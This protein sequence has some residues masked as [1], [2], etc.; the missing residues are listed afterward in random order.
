MPTPKPKKTPKKKKAAPKKKAPAKKNTP[1]KAAP[2]KAAQKK[3]AP[4]K[5]V[6]G[7]LLLVDRP[8]ANQQVT[9]VHYDVK[10]FGGPGEID[11]SGENID[12]TLT[13]DD[14]F[15]VSQTIGS[16]VTFVGGFTGGGG[17]HIDVTVTENGS[18]IGSGSFSGNTFNKAIK[19]TVK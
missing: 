18:Q 2:K 9:T 19:Y 11:L 14:N 12:V 17:A 8:S 1:K 3:A 7:K 4:E 15:D 6:T 16:Q 13:S 5:K 10:F